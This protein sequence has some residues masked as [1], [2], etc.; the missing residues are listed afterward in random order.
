MGSSL[1]RILARAYAPLYNSK[2][3]RSFVHS[4]QAIICRFHVRWSVT[5]VCF[6]LEI[7][8]WEQVW[9]G[10]GLQQSI[11]S[12]PSRPPP[13]GIFKV[14]LRLPWLTSAIHFVCGEWRHRHSWANLGAQLLTA[15]FVLD[16]KFA[17]YI[18][19]FPRAPFYFTSSS[20]LDK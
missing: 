17:A 20:F 8:P 19:T 16:S 4:V 3:K 15:R 10:K 11:S 13:S 5:I 6:K 18:L 12:E 2:L 14:N 7:T 9:E 1:S